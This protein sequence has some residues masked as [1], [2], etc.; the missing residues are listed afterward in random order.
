[1]I[2]RLIIPVNNAGIAIR[3]IM[4]VVIYKGRELK[5]SFAPSNEPRGTIVVRAIK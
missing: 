1:M 3:I 2:V 4:A 5:A